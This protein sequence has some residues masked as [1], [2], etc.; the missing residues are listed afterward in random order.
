MI[1]FRSWDAHRSTPVLQGERH[2]LVIEFWQGPPTTASSAEGRPADLPGGRRVLCGPAVAADAAS[3]ALLWDC[4]K[5][6]DDNAAELLDHAARL[7]AGSAF[8]WE[9]A[10]AAASI[11]LLAQLEESTDA[12]TDNTAGAMP[13]LSPIASKLRRAGVLRTE[14]L[15]PN[16]T[17]TAPDEWDED[18]DGVWEPPMVDGGDGQQIGTFFQTQSRSMPCGYPAEGLVVL[19]EMVRKTASFFEFSLCLSRACLGKMIVSIYKW[20]K[21]AVFRRWRREV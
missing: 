16:T 12:D 4:S 7:V 2:I 17:A 10:A 8:L 9:M 21:N 3:A 15:V 13:D 6:A 5:T 11:P 1:L 14:A 20:R 18:E 19:R